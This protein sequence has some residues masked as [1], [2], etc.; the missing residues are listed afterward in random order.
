VQKIGGSWVVD[1]KIGVFRFLQHRPATRQAGLGWPMGVRAG[2]A[3]GL[4]VYGQQGSMGVG[5]R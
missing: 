1:Q 2:G 3:N 4:A 5:E